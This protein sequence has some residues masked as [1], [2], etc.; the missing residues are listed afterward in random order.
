MAAVCWLY[1]RVIAGTHG[2]R[3]LRQCERFAQRGLRRIRIS[4]LKKVGQG[5]WSA[6]G[7]FAMCRP[8]KNAWWLYTEHMGRF[9][10]NGRGY[11]INNC[12]KLLSVVIMGVDKKNVRPQASISVML[13]VEH[14][15]C[16]A[17]WSWRWVDCFFPTCETTFHGQYTP[18]ILFS[19]VLYQTFGCKFC[20]SK[21]YSSSSWN[22]SSAF[23]MGYSPDGELSDSER[24]RFSN[25]YCASHPRCTPISDLFGISLSAYTL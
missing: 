10:R 16:D 4:L 8:T 2:K 21:V 5:P 1:Q 24:A 9:R 11:T 19:V 12:M 22:F 17:L 23:L 3:C 20:F 15:K 7:L 13:V 6:F 14:K 18:R 25:S